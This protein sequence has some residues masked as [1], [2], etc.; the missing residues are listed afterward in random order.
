MSP[1]IAATFLSLDG[2]TALVQTKG[3]Y[4]LYQIY[5][6]DSLLYVKIGTGYVR[7]RPDHKTSK[8][9]VFWNEINLP[10]DSWQTKGINLVW[11]PKTLSVVSK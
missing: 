7:L 4:N 2:A 11:I 10:S 1:K 3:V 9:N 6:Y 5:T 8:D